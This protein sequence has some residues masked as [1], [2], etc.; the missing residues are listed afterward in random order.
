MV[1]NSDQKAFIIQSNGYLKGGTKE[2]C[3]ELLQLIQ[4]NGR[5][6]LKDSD[7]AA[8]GVL[9]AA[10]FNKEDEIPKR[11]CCNW[12]CHYVCGHLCPR[13]TVADKSINLCSLYLENNT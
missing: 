1:L 2:A 10:S 8:I 6:T 5:S 11:W 4:S 7:I 9:I 3:L 12:N 13:K